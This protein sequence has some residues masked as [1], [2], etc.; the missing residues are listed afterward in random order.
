MC[1][2]APP[3]GTG[4]VLRSAPRRRLLEAGRFAR[5]SGFLRGRRIAV[6]VG[7]V[8]DGVGGG[9]VAEAGTLPLVAQHPADRRH[10]VVAHARAFDRVPRRSSVEEPGDGRLPYFHRPEDEAPRLRANASSLGSGSFY[11]T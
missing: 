4:T 11:L 1:R 7:G 10:H 2:R 6:R 3:G 5:R 8:F 9:F